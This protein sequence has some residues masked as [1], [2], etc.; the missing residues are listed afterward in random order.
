L[1]SYQRLVLGDTPER[2]GRFVTT[3]HDRGVGTLLARNPM[4]GAFADRVAF[5]AAIVP[6]AE[7]FVSCDRA[8]FLGPGGSTERPRALA[9][10]QT[11]DGRTGAG[12][13]P[14]FA[15]QSVVTLA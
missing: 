4:A 13:D 1:V 8:T 3:V 14:C 9:S 5:G 6:G 11:L 10:G 7:T 2:G 15:S 12:L